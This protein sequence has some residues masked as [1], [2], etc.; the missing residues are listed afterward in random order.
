MKNR[1]LVILSVLFA[2]GLQTIKAQEQPPIPQDDKNWISSINYDYTGKTIGKS[3]GF[4]NQLGKATQNQSW[5]ILTNK[6][7]NSQILYDSQGRPVFQTLSA[8]HG[9]NFGYNPNFVFANFSGI[10]TPYT[11]FHFEADEDEPAPVSSLYENTLGYYYSTNN[12][13]DYQDIT[14]YPFSRTIFSRLNPGGVKK[15]LGGNK[16]NGEWLQSYSFTMKASEELSYVSAFNDIAYRDWRVVKTVNRDVHGIETVVF[17]DS[18]GKVL[19][20]ARSG[21][22]E[23]GTITNVTK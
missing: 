17:S 3:V 16:V 4:Y 5:D 12:D 6:V 8:P 9:N 2:L 1:I 20:A 7:W 23:T 15:V 21:N 22:E 14:Q 19:A 18:D 10:D 13:N 11:S